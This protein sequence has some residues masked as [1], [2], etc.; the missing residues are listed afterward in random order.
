[1]PAG[2]EMRAEAPEAI[3][4][5]NAQALVVRISPK[6]GLSVPTTIPDVNRDHPC[7]GETL[8]P[9]PAGVKKGAFEAEEPAEN[10]GSLIRY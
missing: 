1:M 7:S 10:R 8:L 3:S 4:V 9:G 2:A 5:P 6:K